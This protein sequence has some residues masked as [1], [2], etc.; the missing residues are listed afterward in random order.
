MRN[1]PRD[2]FRS[3]SEKPF[4]EAWTQKTSNRLIS[5]PRK[6][7]GILKNKKGKEEKN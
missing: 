3:K 6:K 4:G 1:S 5:T 2:T 7:E